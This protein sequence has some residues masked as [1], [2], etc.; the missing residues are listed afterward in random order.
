MFQFNNFSD[1][2]IA[3]IGVVIGIVGILIGAI[4]QKVIDISKVLD[5]LFGRKATFQAYKMQIILIVLVISAFLLSL[6]KSS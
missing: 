6:P 4:F 3:L 2:S 1:S 5:T